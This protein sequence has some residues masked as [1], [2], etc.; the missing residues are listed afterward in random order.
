VSSFGTFTFG[1]KSSLLN[2]L[3]VKLISF[4]AECANG[5]VQLNWSTASEQ[6]NDYFSVERGVDNIDRMET[7]GFRKGAGVSY[8]ILNYTLTDNLSTIAP[9]YRFLYY[10]L[11]QTDFDGT[12]SYSKIVS[13][14]NCNESSQVSVY[15]TISDG[16]VFISGMKSGPVE[17][18]LFNSTG[19]SVYH[20][21]ITGNSAELRLDLAPGFYFYEIKTAENKI[22]TGKLILK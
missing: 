15:P 1:S 3:P 5:D 17:I 21:V 8:N 19:E 7:I 4:G 14:E 2:P 11:K 9:G 16:K 18:E 6:N 22:Q 10:R 13:A 12:I 20:S